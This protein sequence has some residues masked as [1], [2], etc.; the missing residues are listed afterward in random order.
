MA[1]TPAAVPGI[2][3]DQAL[4]ADPATGPAAQKIYLS[5]PD[6]E[7]RFP[8]LYLGPAHSHRYR[9]FAAGHRNGDRVVAAAA[10]GAGSSSFLSLRQLP[11]GQAL[12]SDS[13][14]SVPGVSKRACTGGEAATSCCGGGGA[15]DVDR[16]QSIWD[17]EVPA[18]GL[19]AGGSHHRRRGEHPAPK[20]RS[21]QLRRLASAAR[22]V[23]NQGWCSTLN[24]R[25]AASGRR[26]QGACA[27]VGAAATPPGP[28]GRSR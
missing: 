13:G 15:G 19:T 3:A 28:C 27:G 12:T 20:K 23:V 4:A 1:Q 17:D 26:C 25:Y 21:Q 18:I 9:A 16:L 7:R 22:R 2:E 6:T 11:S 24:Q 10:A 5:P 8:G 14:T